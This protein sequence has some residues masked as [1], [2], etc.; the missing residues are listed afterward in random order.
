MRA[1][2]LQSI[3]DSNYPASI[4]VAAAKLM[5]ND[6]LDVGTFLKEL[7]QSDLDDLTGRGSRVIAGTDSIVDFD[8]LLL[9]AC[10]LCQAEGGMLDDSATIEARTSN[11]II[12]LSFEDLARKGIIEFHREKATLCNEHLDKDIAQAL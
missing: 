6:Y 2:S 3:V 8:S 11:L 10:M 9:L 1:I 5:A 7:T 4:R 12:L